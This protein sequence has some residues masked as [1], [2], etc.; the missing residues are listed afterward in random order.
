MVG[1]NQWNGYVAKTYDGEVYKVYVDGTLIS[2]KNLAYSIPTNTIKIGSD[3]TNF[4]S[5]NFNGI[6]GD[7]QSTVKH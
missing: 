2:S 5:V 1:K 4:G 3:F 6:I 7:V